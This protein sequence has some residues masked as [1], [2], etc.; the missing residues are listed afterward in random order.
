MVSTPVLES[1]IETCDPVRTAHRSMVHAAHGTVQHK[2]SEMLDLF[3]CNN[4]REKQ[5][6]SIISYDTFSER[7]FS[8]VNIFYDSADLGSDVNEFLT[9]E[10]SFKK[11]SEF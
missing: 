2:K 5:G 3:T 9:A 11:R 6:Y 10:C 4:F 1:G 7:A 8:V